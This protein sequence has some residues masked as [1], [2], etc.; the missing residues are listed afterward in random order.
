MPLLR[1]QMVYGLVCNV[2]DGGVVKVGT[3]LER[4]TLRLKPQDA[5]VPRLRAALM[6]RGWK[7]EELPENDKAAAAMPLREKQEEE[8]SESE[9]LPELEP[10]ILLGASRCKLQPL[11]RGEKNEVNELACD[12]GQAWDV[13]RS[14][15]AEKELEQISAANGQILKVQ[16]VARSATLKRNREERGE[17][18]VVRCKI[19][20]EA[21]EEHQH[22]A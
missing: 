15:R 4:F 7:S 10:T 16:E 6:K 18:H 13:G 9:Q 5:L 21:E 20:C 3:N 19:P 12:L 11:R 2:Y 22:S 1:K 17:V 8:Q 14:S